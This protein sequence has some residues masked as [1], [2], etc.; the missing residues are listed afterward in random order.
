MSSKSAR[1]LWSAKLTG[2][3]IPGKSA[4]PNLLKLRK[5]YQGRVL[6]IDPSL[7]NTGL[8]VIE[9]VPRK[10]PKLLFNQTVKLR[11]ALSMPVCLGEISRAVSAV[12]DSTAVDHVAL[13]QTIYVQ[14]FQT[15]QILGAVRGAAIAAVAVRGLPVA[16]YPPLRI[17]QAVVGFGRASKAQVTGMIR[18]LLDLDEA[19]APDESDAAGAAFCHVST[20]REA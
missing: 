20:Y 17:K 3:S 12:L 15:A 2:K 11:G 16:E 9:F 10:K 14:N 1:A 7:R 6:G 19:L 5:H 18:S 13:E 4:E 8:V